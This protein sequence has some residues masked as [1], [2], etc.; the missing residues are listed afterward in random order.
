MIVF[1]LRPGAVSGSVK[2]THVT[3]WHWSHW[4]YS[5]N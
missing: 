1:F 2:A 4:L 5:C 3:N